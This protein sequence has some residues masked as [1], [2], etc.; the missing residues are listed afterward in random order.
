MRFVKAENGFIL[1]CLL[2]AGF[3]LSNASRSVIFLQDVP[4]GSTFPALR[5]VTAWT[6]K[7]GAFTLSLP[8]GT[9]DGDLLV[10]M[11]ETAGETITL[12]DWVEVSCSPQSIG[13][14]CPGGADCTSITMWTNDWTTGENLTTSDSGDHQLCGVVG[15]QVGTFDT[16]DHEDGC[17]GGTQAATTAVSIAGLTTT[18]GNVFVLQESVAALPDVNKSSEYA[19]EANTDL[20]DVTELR[21]Q[22]RNTNNGGC[23]A[24]YEGKNATPDAVGATTSTAATSSARAGI[25][26]GIKPAP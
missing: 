26:F 21:D 14:G 5:G 17:T 12:A 8:V 20:T 18:V 2:L 10:A 16:A 1:A 9:V 24:V 15:F 7:G 23:V 22:C 6:A 3:A 11:C 19:G 4:A 25:M 13:T